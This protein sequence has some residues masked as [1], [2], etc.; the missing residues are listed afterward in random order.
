MSK[1]SGIVFAAAPATA[2]ATVVASSG[3][4]ARAQFRAVPVNQS[5]TAPAVTVRRLAAIKRAAAA[6]AA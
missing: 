1:L 5:V 3:A 2:T 6:A 4:L